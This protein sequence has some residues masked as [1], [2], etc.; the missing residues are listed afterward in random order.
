MAFVAGA[1][2]SASRARARVRVCHLR[3]SATRKEEKEGEGAGEGARAATGGEK[4]AAALRGRALSTER[5]AKISAALKGRRKSDAHR[6]NLRRRF[7]GEQNP[8]FGRKLSLESRR[9]ISRALSGRKRKKKAC[10]AKE[11]SPDA[12]EE[13]PRVNKAAL[14]R[15]RIKAMGSRLLAEGQ[16]TTTRRKAPEKR[17]ADKEL[18]K[19]LERL[20]ER[21]AQLDEPPERVVRT[22]KLTEKRE[23]RIAKEKEETRGAPQSCGACD[24]SG[25]VECPNCVG[26]FGVCSARCEGCLGAGAVFCTACHGVGVLL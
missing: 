25:F 1:A 8:M 16:K 22:R 13:A 26:A 24:G 9:K 21:V 23:E 2:F 5:K 4:T 3:A 19:D 17:A 14:D 7:E 20:L 15:L 18:A 10:V 12:A 11:Q 6:E